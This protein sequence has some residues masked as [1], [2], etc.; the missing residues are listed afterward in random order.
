MKDSSKLP[1]P[2]L[3]PL[4]AGHAP[5]LMP[6]FQA[7]QN[8]LGFMP[9]SE[10]IMQ[11]R[12]KLVQALGSLR[13]AVFDP[14]GEVHGGF[15]RLIGHVASQAAGCRYCMAHTA[16]TSLLNGIEE[17]RLAAVWDYRSS[18]L[19]TEAEKIAL[20]FALAAGSVPNDVTDEMFA[21]LRRHWND[22]QV[23]E[24]VAVISLFGFLNRW[25][26]TMATPLEAKP[27]GV[28]EKF[29]QPHGW[30]VGKHGS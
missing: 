2:R 29:L 8:T 30:S 9:N 19:F 25:N 24:I 26:D 5:E 4:P 7:Y 20:D 22:N 10:L 11:R 1:K 21:E 27:R 6:I 12:P 14:E 13:A 16:G 15:R 28:G 23:V 3:E 17:Q 18:P